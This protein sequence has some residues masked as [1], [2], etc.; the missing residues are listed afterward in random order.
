ML[1]S[2]FARPVLLSLALISGPALAQDLPTPEGEALLTVTGAITVTN[3]GDAAVFDRE[4]LAALDPVTFETTTIWTD[5]TQS[6]TGVPLA[7]LLDRLGAEGS[8]VSATAVNDYAIEIPA[9]DWEGDPDAEGPIVAYLHNDAP[10]SL[11]G[12][13]PLWIVY[14]YDSDPAFRSEVIYSRSIW[15]LDRIEVLP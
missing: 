3:D 7:Q 1:L 11:R 14:P 4:M 6:F 2:R 8:A 13:G 5:G 9:E 12:K 10:M 15:Q